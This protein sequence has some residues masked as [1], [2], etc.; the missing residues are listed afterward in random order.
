M[1]ITPLIEPQVWREGSTLALRELAPSDAGALEPI[2]GDPDVMRHIDLGTLDSAGVAALLARA[3]ADQADPARRGYRLGIVQR[4]DGT[5]VGTI[6][7]DVQGLS[8]AHSHSIILRPGMANMTAGFEAVHLIL[9]VAF[10][11][12]ELSHV[13]C[14]CYADNTVA[15]RLF[16]ATGGVLQAEHARGFHFFSILKDQW[17]DVSSL[18]LREALTLLRRNGAVSPAI[19]ARSGRLRPQSPA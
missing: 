15:T 16:L 14:T 5:L 6:A 7:L 18:T 17:R 10:E 2:L 13:W 12:L 8:N 1:A 4:G 11:Q 9:G 19:A 3:R